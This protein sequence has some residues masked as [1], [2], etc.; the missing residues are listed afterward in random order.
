MVQRT[1]EGGLSRQ[2]RVIVLYVILVVVWGL[3]W[4]TSKLALQSCPP[5]LFAGLR[6]LISGVVLL[7]WAIKGFG[8]NGLRVNLIL[9]L[10]NI[11]LFYGLQNIALQRLPAGLLAIVVYIQP[12]VTAVVARVWLREP[13]NPIK[14]V[15]IAMGFVGVG[16]I[17]AVQL[18]G[19]QTS[20]W[21][22]LLGLA[23]GFSWAF[24][25]VVYKRYRVDPQPLHDVGVQLTVGGAL[26]VGLGSVTERWSQI[27]WSGAF[28]GELLFVALVGTSLAWAIWSQ[29]LKT[30]EASQVAAWTFLV[31]VIST[32]I[33]V[34][35]MGEVVT[36]GLWLGGAGVILGLYLVNGVRRK[37]TQAPP[38]AKAHSRV[39]P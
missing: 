8:K 39:Q 5:V 21:Y 17:S 31:P 15:G 16:V 1:S 33:A 13:L 25:T 11:F 3:V 10:L 18:H 38:M 36:L 7:P 23:A 34:L 22:I 12:V 14:A 9:S 35:W 19:H 27:H 32:I 37:G 20:G 29:L 24:G 6:V 4:P 26:L 30:G 28:W 2:P